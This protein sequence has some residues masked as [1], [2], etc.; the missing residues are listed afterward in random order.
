MG[1]EAACNRSSD[2]DVLIAAAHAVLAVFSAALDRQQ[3]PAAS[4][5]ALRLLE[6]ALEPYDVR[7]CRPPAPR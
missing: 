6:T 2:E 5:A 4:T 1:D 3:L 7:A